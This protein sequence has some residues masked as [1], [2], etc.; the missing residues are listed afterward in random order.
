VGLTLLLPPT[1]NPP[2]PL[3]QEPELAFAPPPPGFISLPLP[4][5]ASTS[6]SLQLPAPSLPTQNHSPL[7]LQRELEQCHQ[8]IEKLSFP[9]F[10]EEKPHSLF[11]LREIPLRE[12][13][14]GFVNAP[15]ISSEV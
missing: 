13:E 2:A 9:Q 6:T 1:H 15:L 8:D 11:P 4:S 7:Q 5:I 3:A 12:G 10:E 14:I